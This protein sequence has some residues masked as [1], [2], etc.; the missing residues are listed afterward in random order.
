M[1]KRKEQAPIDIEYLLEVGT[2]AKRKRLILDLAQLEV[3][4]AIGVT[5]AA[6]AHFEYGVSGMSIDKFYK[7]CQKLE[8]SSDELLGLEK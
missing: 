7:L 3:A 6:Y 2:R 8:I 1:R 4:E 5:R